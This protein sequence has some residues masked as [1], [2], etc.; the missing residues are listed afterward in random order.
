[1]NIEDIWN[2]DKIENNDLDKL[3]DTSKLK[4][5]HPTH[6]LAQIKRSLYT[7]IFW[8][9]LCV[10]FY[11]VLMVRYR[12]WQV[13]TGLALG[14]IF[15]LWVIYTTYQQYKLIDERVSGNNSLLE[16]LQRHYHNINNWIQLQLKVALFIYPF[17]TTSGFML[18]GYLGSHK[19]IEVFMAK[20]I[21]YISWFISTIVLTIA[22]YY[23]AKWMVKI[24][25][26]KHLTKLQ[27]N[28]E[29]LKRA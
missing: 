29:D 15:T 22:T 7:S 24:T 20:P 3:L 2:N 17:S 14:L 23:L 11:I 10:P 6:L 26:G 28:I 16:E 5:H 4:K 21:V 12:L 8:Y 13:E 27:E 19:T 1:M 9:I 25:Y 18:G